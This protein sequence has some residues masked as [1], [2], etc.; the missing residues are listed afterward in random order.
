LPEQVVGMARNGWTASIGIDGRHGP[1]CA[2]VKSNTRGEAKPEYS[3]LFRLSLSCSPENS[4][5]TSGI[6]RPDFAKGWHFES[7]HSYRPRGVSGIVDF[8]R[9]CWPNS[10]DFRRSQEL[11]TGKINAAVEGAVEAGAERVVV[12]DAHYRGDNMLIEQLHPAAEMIQGSMR[13]HWLPWIE[14][15]FDAFIQV[16]AHAMAGTPNAA[17]CHSMELDIVRICLN[18]RATGEIGMA[19]AAA[20]SLGLPTALISGDQA[21]VDEML[22][23]VPQTEGVAV[24]RSLSRGLSCQYAPARARQ[25][26]RDGVTRALQRLADIPPYQVSPPYRLQITYVTPMAEYLQKKTNL[27]TRVI[28]PTTIEYRADTLLQLFTIF[29]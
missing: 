23:L 17:L 4:V 7:I 20:G 29:E 18:D 16:G 8:G 11:L 19:A 28:D 5:D 15:G 26:I 9:Q 22:E 2:V 25:L 13:P 6:V 21:A 1:D 27:E 24:K 3:C 10:P 14:E 12:C